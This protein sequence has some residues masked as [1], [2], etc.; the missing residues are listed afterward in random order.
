MVTRIYGVAGQ[1]YCFKKR[2]ASLIVG[3]FYDWLV[4]LSA[5]LVQALWVDLK[6][7]VLGLPRPLGPGALPLLL[8]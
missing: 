8:G 2:G 1:M 6:F 4:A 5:V 7:A 3:T